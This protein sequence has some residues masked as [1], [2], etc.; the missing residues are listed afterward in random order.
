MDEEKKVVNVKY[1]KQGRVCLGVAMVSK[2]G[3]IEGRKGLP[4][5]YTEKKIVSM[6][7]FNALLNAEI[8]RVKNLES[9]HVWCSGLA[10]IETQILPSTK[11]DILPRIGKK[12]LD[13]LKAAGFT[14]CGDLV[15]LSNE[16]K[17]E[18]LAL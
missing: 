10:S 9:S 14:S 5:S 12:T 7:Q 3:N 6:N 15:N 11:L 2:D 17:R 13:I 8:K 16:R 4:F 1:T 18:L